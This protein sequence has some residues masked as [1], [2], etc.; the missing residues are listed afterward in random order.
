MI[1]IFARIILVV[2][3]I[4]LMFQDIKNRKISWPLLLVMPVA[5][6]LTGQIESFNAEYFGNVLFN[7]AFVI[8]Q[9]AIAA[10]Y[11]FLKEKKVKNLINNKLGIGDILFL[12][13]ITFIFSKVNFIVFYVSGLLFSMIIY[14]FLLGLKAVKQKTIPLA[15]L[16]SAYLLIVFVCSLFLKFSFLNDS[17]LINIL[18]L[19]YV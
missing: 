5:F 6:F 16:L 13:S 10:G 14:L 7:V 8:L 9:L 1:T 15:G 11:F 19:L 12:L 18:S 17:L 2:S 3:L 4:F